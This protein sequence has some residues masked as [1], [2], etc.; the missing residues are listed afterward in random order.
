VPKDT[1]SLVFE[2][3]AFDMDNKI[4]EDLTKVYVRKC[5]EL[6]FDR[7]A[8]VSPLEQHKD[9]GG[10]FVLGTPGVGKSMFRNY[11]CRR[12]VQRA[13]EAE[14]ALMV[15]FQKADKDGAT[16][17]IYVLG[18]SEKGDMLE[19]LKYGP[20]ANGAL[21]ARIDAA[22]T[23]GTT[24]VVSL[25][26]VSAGE[27]K[28]C[29]VST[30][31]MWFFS[32][33]NYAL[34][35]ASD[36]LKGHSR[37]ASDLWMPLWDMDEVLDAWA[38][39][40]DG[41]PP[42]VPPDGDDLCSAFAPGT[43]LPKEAV[44]RRVQEYGAT[45][46]VAFARQLQEQVVQKFDEKLSDKLWTAE[47]LPTLSESI[48]SVTARASHSLIHADVVFPFTLK[49]RTLRWA[50]AKIK[51]TVAAAALKDKDFCHEALLVADG[52]PS[53]KGEM[54]EALWFERFVLATA[55]GCRENQ[56]SLACVTR[57]K[58]DQ[59]VRT[60]QERLA[61]FV[62]MD[63][64]WCSKRVMAA[65]TESA[66]DVGTTDR[67]DVA[68]LLRPFESDMMAV[69]GVL[70]F[71]MGD[72]VWCLLLQATIAKNHGTKETAAAYLETL[73]AAAQSKGATVGLVFVLP[74]S[75]YGGTDGKCDWQR[76]EI[77]EAAV[78]AN[79]LEQYA[80]CPGVSVHATQDA[81]ASKKRGA[82]AGAGAGAVAK[83][84]K[85]KK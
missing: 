14:K 5:Y 69:D 41:L 78:E 65:A 48:H 45:A 10:V 36:R 85:K 1:N 63:Q 2:H 27:Y 64:R 72:V 49:Q 60:L 40:F 76:Q 84:A 13:R 33:P 43:A 11:V 7:M 21:Y 22:H 39:L 67:E 52:G 18:Y 9:H 58:R 29:R 31:H 20:E 42:A 81:E 25:I 51:A 54:V 15:L 34:M 80:L 44:V 57:S 32:S 66:C 83:K 46:R 55:V 56:V 79:K 8:V 19:V 70:V 16:Q 74:L 37:A 30:H 6:L 4:D 73:V 47:L 75:R 17:P 35:T 68:V 3:G 28:S 38:V 82:G 53:F 12:L 71:R 62:S 23:D 24:I 59:A 50:S 77:H 26:D 61:S